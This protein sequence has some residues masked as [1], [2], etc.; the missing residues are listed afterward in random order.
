MSARKHFM[1]GTVLKTNS[2]GPALV[3]RRTRSIAA[4]NVSG[5]DDPAG[6]WHVAVALGTTW[7]SV[8][9]VAARQNSGLAARPPWIGPPAGDS[10]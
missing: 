8:C 3:G 4:N 6:L 5:A 10:V 9:P 7:R 1:V 2:V